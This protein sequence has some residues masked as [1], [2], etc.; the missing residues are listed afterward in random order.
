MVATA[1]AVTSREPAAATLVPFAMAAHPQLGPLEID[2]SFGEGGGQIVRSSLALA[3]LTG[4]GVILDNIRAKRQKPGLARQHLTAVNAAAEISAADVKGASVG[5]TRLTFFPK[6][7]AAGDY[8]FDIGTAGST[9]LVLQT[10]L[11]PLLLA[12]GPSR[13][14]IEG[15]THNPMAPP[16]DFIQSAY[17]PL[18]R[19]FGPQVRLTLDRYG[20]YPKGGGRITVEIEPT[21]KFAYFELL[22]RSPAE[23][24]A[25][26]LL[27][28][29]P[30]HIAD[31]ELAV[32]RETG[33]VRHGQE[34][35]REVTA[36][37]PGNV[38]LIEL[39]AAE[40]T[41]VF[42]ALGERGVRA[43][44]VA[45]AAAQEVADHLATG[46]PIGPHLADQ[47]ILPLALSASHGQG[48]RFRT[49]PL[50]EHSRTHLELVQ[51]FL[52]VTAE[53]AE[54]DGQVEIALRHAGT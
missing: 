16:V 17:L 22:T 49:G 46:A 41:E 35:V 6:R 11:M 5:S 53:V 44:D 45:R 37:S 15:G 1:E 30:R 14:V 34:R 50:T 47:L 13:V 26:V 31:R 36:R 48:G 32:L 12:D 18:V 38:V 19:R 28:D 39:A 2:G 10:L 43:E 29:L 54:R 27:A 25:T 4:R 23:V 7:L 51:R 33:T 21:D 20:F 40:V 3:I 52:P 24:T 42:S 8:H 9:T